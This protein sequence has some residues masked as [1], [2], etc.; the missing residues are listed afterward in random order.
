MPKEEVKC[1]GRKAFHGNKTFFY[2]LPQLLFSKEEEG[3]LQPNQNMNKI[4]ASH[5]LL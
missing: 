4:L 5:A 2:V 1:L 3:Q